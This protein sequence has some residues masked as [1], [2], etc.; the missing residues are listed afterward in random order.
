MSGGNLT[1]ANSVSVSVIFAYR[2]TFSSTDQVVIERT[3]VSNSSDQRLG[4]FEGWGGIKEEGCGK[5]RRKD[6]GSEGG[7]GRGDVPDRRVE[8]MRQSPDE[9]RDGSLGGLVDV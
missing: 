7:E 6:L 3:M 5:R 9:R 1:H 2:D 8:I 4:E